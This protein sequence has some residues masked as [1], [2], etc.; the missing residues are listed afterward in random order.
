MLLNVKREFHT[1]L[2][3]RSARIWLPNASLN[4]RRKR[5]CKTFGSQK[6]EKVKSLI[7]KAK[8]MDFMAQYISFF[9][10]DTN[11]MRIGIFIKITIKKFVI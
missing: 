1:E 7:M 3:A 4:F 8:R 2:K 6:K 10:F 9:L 5:D 11:K